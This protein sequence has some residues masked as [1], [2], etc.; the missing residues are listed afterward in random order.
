ML[1]RCER[2]RWMLLFAGACL[3]G[4]IALAGC[5]GG[6]TT[7]PTNSG[8]FLDGTWRFSADIT[9]GVRTCSQAGTLGLREVG[10]QGGL[11]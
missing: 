11:T 6:S 4:V 2:R 10:I 5:G 7:A 1:P 9:D 3:G 8:P